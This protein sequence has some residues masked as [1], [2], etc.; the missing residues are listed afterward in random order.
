MAWISPNYTDTDRGPNPSTDDKIEVFRDRVDGWQISI[1]E[2]MLRQIEN[3]KDFPAMRHA[4]YA[5]ISVVFSY[6]EMVGQCKAPAGSTPSPTADFIRGFKAIY[7]ATQLTDLEI[8]S[9]YDRV[10]CGMYHNGYTKRGVLIDSTFTP[11][12]SFNHGNLHL[13]PHT[14]VRDIRTHFSDFIKALCAGNNHNDRTSFE[15]LFD[16]V[17]NN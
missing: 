17:P 13:N 6:F 7:P 9:V 3:S 2:E 4:G 10:R 1:A 11:T 5:L 15:S 12:F 8:K 14:L 16:R